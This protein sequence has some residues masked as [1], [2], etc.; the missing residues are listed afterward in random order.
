MV[1]YILVDSDLHSSS[2]LCMVD[3]RGRVF[4][5]HIVAVYT[6]ILKNSPGVPY[7]FLCNK[8]FKKKNQN[9]ASSIC[10]SSAKQV[11]SWKGWLGIWVI[12]LSGATCLPVDCFFNE[13]ALLI[14][15]YLS[16]SK[17]SS[18]FFH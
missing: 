2:R 11:V 12:C 10:C 16:S 13:P 9:Y 7:I 1:W 3:K 14:S 15:H 4:G 6:I 8:L 5:T 18:S 17:K